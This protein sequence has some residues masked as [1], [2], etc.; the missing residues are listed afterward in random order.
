[1]G[2][3][4]RK[5]WFKRALAFFPSTTDYDNGRSSI[6]ETIRVF[7]RGVEVTISFIIII[8]Q[9]TVFPAGS[10]IMGFPYNLFYCVCCT[11]LSR[12]YCL[13]PLLFIRVPFF[14][15]LPSKLL[16]FLRELTCFRVLFFSFC[17]PTIF[18]SFLFLSWDSFFSFTISFSTVK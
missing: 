17:F 9:Q 13:I 14:S 8:V 11:A 18:L 2:K 5:H 1:M 4:K 6:R 12:P 10:P 7:L 3:G 16:Y 15:L